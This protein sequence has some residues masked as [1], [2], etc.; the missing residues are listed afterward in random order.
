LQRLK[1]LGAEYR[2][3]GQLSDRIKQALRS[4][5]QAAVEQTLG[6]RIV[7]TMQSR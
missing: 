2:E 7:K 6:T 5:P 1:E 4:R 3:D